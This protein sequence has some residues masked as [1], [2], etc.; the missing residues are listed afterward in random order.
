MSLTKSQ[1]FRVKPVTGLVEIGHP[2]TALEG[3]AEAL[4]LTMDGP[5]TD[6]TYSATAEGLTGEV[7]VNGKDMDG[8][9]GLVY[10]GP[11]G[12]SV[13][14]RFSNVDVI[15]DPSA[16]PEATD[17]VT[18]GVFRNNDL[19][20]HADEGYVAELDTG[21]AEFNGECTVTNLQTGDVLRVGL[22]MGSGSEDGLDFLVEEGGEFVLV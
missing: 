5:D 13:D 2:V 1:A 14:V 11:V 20:G 7:A 22:I 21:T 18:L 8:E 3:A 15:G 6:W 10:A 9:P 16:L 4:A 19:V 17:K 12:G